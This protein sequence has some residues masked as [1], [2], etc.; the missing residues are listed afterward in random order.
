MGYCFYC[1]R[2]IDKKSLIRC[3]DC[4]MLYCKKCFVDINNKYKCLNC[5]T[6]DIE[7]YQEE[8]LNEIELPDII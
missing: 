7:Q 1:Q 3:P 8:F 5:Y 4:D 6:K 2:N